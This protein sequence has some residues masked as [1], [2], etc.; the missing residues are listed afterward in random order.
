[1]IELMESAEFLAI[2]GGLLW[3]SQWRHQAE[4]RIAQLEHQVERMAELVVEMEEKSD[5]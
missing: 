5:G 2:V 4:A 3:F 1:M